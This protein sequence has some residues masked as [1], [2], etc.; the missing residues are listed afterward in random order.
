MPHFSERN[1]R[2]SRTPRVHIQAQG[3]A[4]GN[5]PKLWASDALTKVLRSA[6]PGDTMGSKLSLSGAR[7]EIVSGQAVFLSPKDVSVAAAAMSDL[8]NGG[9]GEVIPGSAVRL[10][11]V[12]IGQESVQPTLF[13]ERGF[14]GS[15]LRISGHE[16]S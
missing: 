4:P 5:G 12:R 15:G 2:G 3:E 7:R 1:V 13:R 8:R 9:S 6:T 11:W 16:M 10:Q 14:L